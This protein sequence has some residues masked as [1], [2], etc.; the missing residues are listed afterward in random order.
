MSNLFEPTALVV[1]FEKLRMNDVEIVGGKNASLGEMISQLPEGVR[2]PTGFATTAHAFREF[3]KADGLNDRINV[4]LDALDTD[5]VRAL[6]EAGAEIRAMVESQ[7]FPADLEAAIRE[8]FARL[9]EGNPDASFAV[10]SSATAE[11]LPDAS[12]AGQQET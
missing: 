7:P 5:D 1:P 4:R 12:F 9:S 3:L 8:E 10:R 11:D 6:A 2:V